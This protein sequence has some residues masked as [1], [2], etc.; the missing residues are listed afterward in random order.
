MKGKKMKTVNRFNKEITIRT[1]C[2]L[3][4]HI[5]RQAAQAIQ[6]NPSKAEAIQKRVDADASRLAFAINMLSVKV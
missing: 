2:Q 1:L 5:Y 4:Q 6:Q 3:K